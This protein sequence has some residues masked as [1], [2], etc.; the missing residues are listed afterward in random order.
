MVTSATILYHLVKQHGGPV[1]VCAR[2]NTAIDRLNVV[3]VCAKSRE[4]IDTPVSH[5]A[6]HIKVKKMDG[7]LELQKLPQT[8]DELSVSDEKRYC[9]LRKQGDLVICCTC[10]GSPPAD[11]DEVL[12]YPH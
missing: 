11:A 4:A 2:S 7:S 1:H 5:L 6:L 12:L 9:M 10:I 3:R 8:R